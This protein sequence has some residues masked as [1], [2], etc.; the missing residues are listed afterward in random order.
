MATIGRKIGLLGG[1]FDPVHQG[2]L[3]IAQ[4]A[5]KQ[6]HLDEVWFLPTIETPL[7]PHQL[8]PLEQR[9]AMLRMLLKPYPKL[10]VSLI[11]QKNGIPSYSINTAR[12]LNRMYPH[13]N[14]FW[15]IGS[16]WA[17]KLDTWKDIDELKKLVTFVCL[18]RAEDDDCSGLLTVA[19]KVHPASSTAIRQ[20]NF[21]YIPDFEKSYIM[22]NYLYQNSIAQS[23]VKPTRWPHVL[24]VADLAVRIAKGNNM[25]CQQAYQAGL[26]HDC[27]KKMSDAEMEYW[28][29][30][31]A[32]ETEYRQSK[33]V[34]HQYVGASWLS[35]YLKLNDHQVITAIRHHALGDC[36]Q[37]LA[38]I[39]YAADKLDPLRGYDS[40]ELIEMCCQDIRTGFAKVRR[41][42]DAYL[43]SQG[44]ID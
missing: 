30:F 1:S 11:E 8:A 26:F 25:N 19:A 31:C 38:M 24:S 12:R 21:S 22:S 37:P 15:I 29:S 14:F 2:H 23:T 6:L 35:R 17:G 42:Q 20:G 9:T 27:A 41:Q 7:K 34:W 16:D 36:K 3:F 4:T 33:D 40:Q 28:M 10:K 43:R 18:K 5:L 13:D 32:N 39:I 44:V